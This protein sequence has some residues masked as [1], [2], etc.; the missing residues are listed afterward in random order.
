[1]PTL[2]AALREG[3]AR[4]WPA[5]S[6]LERALAEVGPGGLAVLPLPAGNRMAGACLIGWDTP[7]DFGT[8]E[9]ALLTACAGLAGQALV[10]ARAF[11]AEHE[12]VG[13][14]QRQL[15]P[16]SLPRLPGAVAVAR[17][18]PSTAGLELGGDWYDVIPLPDNHVAL[19]IGDVQGHSAGA[20]TLMGQ[21]RTALRAYAVEGHPPDV[22]VAHAN[23]LLMDMES[24]LFATCC[25]VDV[26]LEEGAAW[27]VRA[28]H[29][30]PVLRYPDGRTEIAEAEGGPPLGVV[31]R[32]D[33]P[34]SPLR[35]PPGTVIA[36]ATDGLVET[37][38]SDI[39]EG[40]EHLAELLAE[41]APTDMGLVADALLGNAPRTDDVA[42]LLLRYDGM[43]LRPLRES[44]TVWRVPQAVG[45]ARRF[46]RRTLRSWGVTVDYDAALLVVSELVTN[47]LVHT[48]GKVR[49]DLTLVNNR[50]RIAIADASPRSPVRPTSI[51]WE[52]TGGR[53][54]LLV[55]A[56]A[57]TWGTLPVS[58]GKQ[59]WAELLLGR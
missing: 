16:R 15:L 59:V 54:I 25:Y 52:A 9:R 14:L 40:M 4:I 23:R 17:Y 31:T 3:R 34:M 56:L 57:A 11:D 50:L 48:D 7:H 29:L 41:A 28:G 26:D 53:G 12:L 42:L 32:A 24:D 43:E 8:D 38:D 27:C 1:M 45:H 30:P 46:A 13:M 19:V 6:P 2:A 47:A 58:G 20:A 51:G 49:M 33:F 39:D 21:M 35:L 10:R 36:L 44:W 37:P 5:G 18:L 22:V 55:E